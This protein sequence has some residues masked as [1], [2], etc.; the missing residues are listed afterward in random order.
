[1]T[2][3]PPLTLKRYLTTQVAIAARQVL[4]LSRTL[5]PAAGESLQLP[6]AGPAGTSPD[7]ATEDGPAA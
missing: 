3:N 7:A 4:L 5:P 2:S 1:M 6:G